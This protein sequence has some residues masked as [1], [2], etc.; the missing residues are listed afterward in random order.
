MLIVAVERAR[1][2]SDLTALPISSISNESNITEFDLKLQKSEYPLLNLL[3]DV[4]Y[5][6]TSKITTIHTSDLSFHVL[7]NLKIEYPEVYTEVLSKIDNF[8]KEMH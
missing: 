7:S 6:R 2:Q 8:I 5:I 3:R 4:S 1:G